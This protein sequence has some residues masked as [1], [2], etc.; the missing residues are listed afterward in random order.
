MGYFVQITGDA[1]S[2][3]FQAAK[4]YPDVSFASSALFHGL[5]TAS[6]QQGFVPS[7]LRAQDAVIALA[8]HGVPSTRLSIALVTSE[9][10]AGQTQELEVQLQWRL[11]AV[12]HGAVL[13]VGSEALK[14]QPVDALRRLLGQ[15]LSPIVSRLM[16]EEPVPGMCGHVPCLGL[17]TPIAL[18]EWLPGCKAD[19]A[20]QRLVGS[21]PAGN[22][23]VLEGLSP[24]ATHRAIAVLAWQGRV[25]A[26]TPAWRAQDA[27]YRS[28]LL[29]LADN[30]GPASFENPSRTWSL[31]E[32]DH[33]WLPIAAQDGND[34]AESVHRQ[35]RMLSIRLYPDERSLGQD[36]NHSTVSNVHALEQR[37]VAAGLAPWSSSAS[38]GKTI[39]QSASTVGPP[40]SEAQ[41]GIDTDQV[42]LRPLLGHEPRPEDRSSLWS[43]ENSLVFSVLAPEDADHFAGVQLCAA[44][45]QQSAD[46]CGE[47]LKQ[48]WTGLRLSSSAQC[49]RILGEKAGAAGVVAAVLLDERRRD[50]VVLP[51]VWHT[52]DDLPWQCSTRQQKVDSLRRLTYWLHALPALGQ[53]R[54]QHYAHCED[55]SLAAVRR[56]DGLQ[57]W[58]VSLAS[59]QQ[60]AATTAGE[61]SLFLEAVADI[62]QRVPPSA[63]LREAFAV[64]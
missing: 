38:D 58:G 28:L 51:S 63:D 14:R 24:G 54:E 27:V 26:A 2:P 62:L 48:L 5:V 57:C 11:S 53:H 56:E 35:H 19:G 40:D 61:R 30:L 25:V 18:V 43:E 52:S 32:V 9:L 12:Y 33:L 50:V 42:L 39:E 49:S 60:H 17:A 20:F 13:A 1:G 31:E 22:G 10:S 59:E 3:I 46:L 34:A 7:V 16:A 55:Y 6:L 47:S 37:A 45:L 8:V 64:G 23:A 4:N 29:S 41:S 15:R 44:D 21:L 36:G